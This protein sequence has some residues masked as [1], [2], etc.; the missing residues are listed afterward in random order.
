MSSTTP[1]GPPPDDQ[2]TT[3]S[4]A[5]AG[6]YGRGPAIGL[7]GSSGDLARLPIPGNAEFLFWLLV[8]I[9]FWIITW[10]SDEV[11]SPT[12]VTV[13]AATAFAYL[14]SRG[15]AKAGRVLEQ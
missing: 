2:P 8:T 14:I 9:L 3:T 11:D 1:G 10:A 7:V 13:T 6:D 5:P 12:F 15:I 4:G